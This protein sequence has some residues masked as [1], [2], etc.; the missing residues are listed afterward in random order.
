MGFMDSLMDVARNKAERDEKTRGRARSKADQMKNWDK[1]K[2]IEA[3][4]SWDSETAK[5]A[6]FILEKKIQS[7]SVTNASGVHDASNE[8]VLASLVLAQCSMVRLGVPVITG[9]DVDL[10]G[11]H[12]VTVS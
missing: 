1:S 3:A 8:K 6:K 10:R 5:V 2:L 7:P 4:S 9:W 11:H 12:V